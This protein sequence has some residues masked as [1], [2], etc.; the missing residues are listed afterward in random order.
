MYI[1]SLHKSIFRCKSF[2]EFCLESWKDYQSIADNMEVQIFVGCRINN[3]HCFIDDFH[4]FHMFLKLYPLY[5]SLNQEYI[6][7]DF[8]F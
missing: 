2:R 1:D 7:Q 6:N 5:L 8:S 3:M 4:L